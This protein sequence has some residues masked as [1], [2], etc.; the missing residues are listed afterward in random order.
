[1]DLSLVLALALLLQAAPGNMPSAFVRRSNR[2]RLAA[3]HTLRKKQSIQKLK[4]RPL[5]PW[6]IVRLAPA[7]T[8]W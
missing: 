2:R 4:G 1:M 6:E 5:I 3:S 8:T 7:K